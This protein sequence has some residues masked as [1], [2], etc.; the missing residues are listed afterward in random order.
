M[1]FARVNDID[2]WYERNGA[3]EPV[4]VISGTGGDLRKKPSVSDGPLARDFD[5][6]TFD[7][8][9]LGQSSKPDQP[10][11][12]A[13][14]ADDAAGLMEAIGWPAAHIVG[15]SFGGMVAQEL[16]LRHP[17]RVK[18]LVLCCTS[19]GG[20]G[21]ASFPFHEVQHLDP[22]ERAKRLIPISDTRADAAWAEANPELYA[23]M[24]EMAASDPYRDEPRREMGARRQ[25][26]ARVG[27]DTWSRLA[28]ITAPTLI[29]GGR[30]DG[31]ALP[32]TQ[33]N[34]AAR[35]PGAQ[36]EF[37]EGGHLFLVQDQSAFAAITRF[38]KG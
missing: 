4:L 27:H 28:S 12:M 5:V 1:T 33:K 3:G 14:Y 18:K 22:V 2:I 8:R 17:D 26:E 10:Y 25:L 15:I 30:Y 31:V 38:L 36:L 9:G 37:F 21:G 34:L 23:L 13:N 16:V 35:I 29:C 32:E 19:P 6:V 24:V 7:Q 20:E 11:S